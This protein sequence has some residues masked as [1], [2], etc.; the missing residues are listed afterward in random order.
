MYNVFVSDFVISHR[1]VIVFYHSF[2]GLDELSAYIEI[3]VHLSMKG[4]TYS[5][6]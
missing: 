5:S 4:L 3:M 6:I 2:C 1:V